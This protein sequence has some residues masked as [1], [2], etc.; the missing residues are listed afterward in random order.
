MP[1]IQF[2][3]GK[4][5]VVNTRYGAS[6][7]KSPQVR[8]VVSTPYDYVLPKSPQRRLGLQPPGIRSP[9]VSPLRSDFFAN[10]SRPSIT[11]KE[12]FVFA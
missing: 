1:V 6:V 11:R 8:A 4:F 10:F 5:F 2:V 7:N 9:L 12:L 3:D